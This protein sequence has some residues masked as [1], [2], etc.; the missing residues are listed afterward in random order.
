MA[1]A[2]PSGVKLSAQ[3]FEVVTR[4]ADSNNF[5][6]VEFFFVVSAVNG[7]WE[8]AARRNFLGRNTLSWLSTS[9]SYLGPSIAAECH[10]KDVYINPKG[11]QL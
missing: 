8:P 3:P 4:A 2:L 11:S 10:P 7:A 1:T 9:T 6:C 5:F